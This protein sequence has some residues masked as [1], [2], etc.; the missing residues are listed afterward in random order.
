MNEMLG[1]IF[2]RLH[3]GDIAIRRQAA[4]NRKNFVVVIAVLSYAVWNESQRLKQRQQ[5]EKLTKEV[6]N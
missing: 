6:R 4:I 5:I 1:Y 2:S 3:D